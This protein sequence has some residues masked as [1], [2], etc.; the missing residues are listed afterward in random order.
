MNLH[1][2]L[3]WFYSYS[4]C[5]RQEKGMSC[6]KYNVCSD[7]YSFGWDNA[8][9]TSL[10]G[11]NCSND[12][13][14]ITGAAA[15]CNSETTVARYCGQALQGSSAAPLA[16]ISGNIGSDTICGMYFRGFEEHSEYIY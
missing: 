11:S 14:E 4:I 2:N 3:N 10:I 16:T 9:I 8:A 1:Q 7:T 6:I 13:V 15:L 5:I 12:F